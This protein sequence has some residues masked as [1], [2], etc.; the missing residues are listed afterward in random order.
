MHTNAETCFYSSLG[1]LSL[2][3]T[4]KILIAV[5]VDT[6]LCVLAVWF[7][8]YLRTG[9]FISLS[10]EAL[11]AAILSITIALPSFFILGLYKEIFRYSGCGLHCYSFFEP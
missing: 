6:T 5:T 9:E 2:P 10:E 1:V 8:F 4:Y 7:A 3:R 11:V